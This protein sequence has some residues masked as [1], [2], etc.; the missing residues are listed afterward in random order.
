[1]SQDASDERANVDFE[2]AHK[3]VRDADKK[4]QLQWYQQNSQ[5]RDP[6]A[7][8]SQRDDPMA[9]KCQQKKIDD[10]EPAAG[11]NSYRR[12][13]SGEKIDGGR[14]GDPNYRRRPLDSRDRH[15]FCDAAHG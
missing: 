4:Q 10:H 5:Y 12:R 7:G 8:A 15:R 1:M 3:Q 13:R 14:D 11:E 6:A 9:D 2:T